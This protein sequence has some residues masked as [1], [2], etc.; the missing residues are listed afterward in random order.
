VDQVGS[1]KKPKCCRPT[2]YGLN[3]V[4]SYCSGPMSLLSP[5]VRLGEREM[6]NQGKKNK[7]Q[8]LKR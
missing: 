2:V 1:F 7:K 8:L 4:P 3:I 6:K 5:Q